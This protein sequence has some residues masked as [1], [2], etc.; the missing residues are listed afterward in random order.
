VVIVVLSV[1]NFAQSE[2]SLFGWIPQYR[3]EY[4][5]GGTPWKPRG[6]ARWRMRKGARWRSGEGLAGPTANP[7][8]IG[9]F[10]QL[11]IELCQRAGGEPSGTLEG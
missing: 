9:R 10:P 2:R 8:D 3:K 5:R 11:S 4:L 6:V 7:D 1:G